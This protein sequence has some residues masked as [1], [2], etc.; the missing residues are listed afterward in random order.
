MPF[1]SPSLRLLMLG[2]ELFLKF[3]NGLRQSGLDVVL[4]LARGADG[5]RNIAIGAVDV[6]EQLLLERADQLYRNIEQLARNDGKDDDDLLFD[7]DR[8]VLRLLEH[9][10]DTLAL[11]E[12]LLG[13]RVEVGAELRERLQLAVL[14][15]RQL[16]RAGRMPE[17]NSSVSRK[18]WPSV[19]EMTLVGI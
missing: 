1:F 12:A 17:L 13:I 3:L 16:E 4:E 15:V 19:I 14:R 10:D 5:L 11:I 9:L 8:T 2:K 6:L 18:I 7:R